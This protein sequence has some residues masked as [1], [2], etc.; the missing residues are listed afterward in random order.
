[1]LDSVSFEGA[2]KIQI[3]GGSNPKPTGHLFA[4][5]KFFDDVKKV[6][7]DDAST[8]RRLRNFKAGGRAEESEL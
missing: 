7:D 5:N 2:T 4:E 1:M 3:R 6:E 8:K